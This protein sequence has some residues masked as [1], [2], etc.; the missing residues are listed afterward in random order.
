MRKFLYIIFLSFLCLQSVVLKA[1]SRLGISLG[2]GVHT[3]TYEPFLGER[4]YDYG[5][6]FGLDY[7]YFFGSYVG[8][9][10][11]A[12]A[13]LYRSKFTFASDFEDA[14]ESVDEANGGCKY[15]LRY[16]VK[17]DEKQQMFMLGAP[18]M[19]RFRLPM[20]KW[21]FHT[22][23]GAAFELPLKSTFKTDGST[24]VKGYYTDLNVEFKDMPNHGFRTETYERSGDLELSKYG[25]SAI[26]DLGFSRQMGDRSSLYL[27]L[28]ASYSLKKYDVNTSAIY[29]EVLD[30]VLYC[31]TALSKDM[32]ETV[33][34]FSV[35]VKLRMSFGLG[36]KGKNQKDEKK[37]EPDD[38]QVRDTL[39]KD[40][41]PQDSLFVA[42]S[43]SVEKTE[44]LLASEDVIDKEI[45][46]KE[47]KKAKP[48]LSKQ[49]GKKKTSKKKTAV[50]KKTGKKNKKV[51]KKSSLAKKKAGTAVRANK[52][53]VNNAKKAKTGKQT[54][55][56]GRVKYVKFL[57]T[58]GSDLTLEFTEAD[59]DVV[60]VEK[61]EKLKRLAKKMKRKNND[62]VVYY[63]EN[64]NKGSNKRVMRKD[65]ALLIKIKRLLL[66]YGVKED[67]IVIGAGN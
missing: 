6:K 24:E 45:T 41:L 36:R 50:K 34:P 14:N 38:I 13:D 22:D 67:Q 26:A 25:V 44:N 62:K 54:Q 58:N 3:L 39:A 8:F 12:Y 29:M 57:C 27:G 16:D 23:L 21:A 56:K 35:G 1:E 64:K 42:D 4:S 49:K 33:A 17:A 11:G 37:L 10:V 65:M 43:T 51:A 20:K 61:Q 28:Y 5:G 40:S 46:K 55:D 7:S 53:S 66:K 19:F 63:S 47:Q 52:K 15:K 31:K 60:S 18:V 32:T 9:S 2:G 30:D 59:G 48:K